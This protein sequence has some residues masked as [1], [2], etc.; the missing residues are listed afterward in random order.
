MRSMRMTREQSRAQ[1]RDRLLTAARGVFARS[2]FHGASVEEIASEAGFSTGALY[3]NFDGKEDLFLAL[4]E[5]EIDEHAREIAE[6]VREQASIAE[7]A[8]G[9][10]RRW[11]TMIEREP[12]VL[13]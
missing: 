7:R 10:A 1:T 6:A 8:T 3:S 9:G 13:L 11:M 5:R 4:M 12:E 2:G